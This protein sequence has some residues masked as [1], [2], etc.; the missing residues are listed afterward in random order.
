MNPP[1]KLYAKKEFID[2]ASF[3]QHHGKRVSDTG[4]SKAKPMRQGEFMKWATNVKS[5]PCQTRRRR[6]RGT[7]SRLI[8]PLAETTMVSGV[9]CSCGFPTRIMG[10]GFVFKGYGS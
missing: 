7:N 1:D 4:R 9:G 10:V 8:Q 5:Q 2:W 6:I 3:I